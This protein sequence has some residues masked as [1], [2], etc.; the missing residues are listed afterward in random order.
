MKLVNGM[1]SPPLQKFVSIIPSSLFNLLFSKTLKLF[2]LH[3]KII[4]IVTI[5]L[6][7]FTSS[8]TS[9]YYSHITWTLRRSFLKTS[10]SFDTDKKVVL[11]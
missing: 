5:D 1:L 11:G 2:Y 9:Y 4:Y 6:T 8:Y 3:K 10:K 7:G